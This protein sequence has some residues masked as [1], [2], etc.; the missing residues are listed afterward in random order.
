M[1]Y[2]S[3][4]MEVEN[5]KYIVQVYHTTEA[6]I[7]MTNLF[8]FSG[9]KNMNMPDI[10]PRLVKQFSEGLVT[11]MHYTDKKKSKNN[12]VL[13]GQSLNQVKTSINKNEYQNLSFMG[14]LKSTKN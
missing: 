1:G 4:G 7:E 5:D 3:K 14:Q 12:V 9:S 10:D 8:N 6:P 2:V 13:T 11:E